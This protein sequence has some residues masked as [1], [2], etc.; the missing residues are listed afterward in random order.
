MPGRTNQLSEELQHLGQVAKDTA[1]QQMEMIRQRGRE[2]AQALED[3]VAAQPL[4]SVLIACGVGFV[5]G[6]I[7][8]RR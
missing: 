6:A 5:L 8:A 7:W 4:K 2:R 3:M 1:S